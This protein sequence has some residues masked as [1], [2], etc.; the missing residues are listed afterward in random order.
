MNNNDSRTRINQGLRE[1]KRH[2]PKH[3]PS[4]NLVPIPRLSRFRAQARQRDRD[5]KKKT[6]SRHLITSIVDVAFE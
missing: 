3:P 2:I 4:R 1:S 5:L 6:L